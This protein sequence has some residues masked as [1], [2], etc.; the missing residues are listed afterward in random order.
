MRSLTTAGLVV[1]IAAAL[2]LAALAQDA[3]EA[4]TT[5]AATT[6]AAEGA[7]PEE[8]NYDASTVLATVDGAEITLGHLVALVERLPDQFRSLPDETL[9]GGLIDQLIDQEL[10][11]RSVSDDPQDDPQAV[12]LHLDNERRAALAQLAVADRL[13]GEVGDA[14]VQDAYDEAF[15]D[16]EAQTEWR[17]SHIIVPTEEEAQTLR[18]EIDGGADFAEVAR[19]RSQDGAAARGGD[20]GWFGPGRMVPEFEA[21]VTEMEEGEV[22]GPIQTQFGWHL[23]RLDETRES[24]P[25]AMETVR[26]QI[27]DQLRQQELMAGVEALREEAEI[28]RPEAGIPASA[29]RDTAILE[30]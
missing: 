19:E 21:A 1:G 11:A 14:A 12:Q 10:L 2:P 22:R 9:M 24:E 29:I 15:A 27:V 6:E 28:D 5:E 17:A 4:A 18:E 23:I 8:R 13:E 3:P 16:F 26:P 25:P 20:L 30:N 7:E